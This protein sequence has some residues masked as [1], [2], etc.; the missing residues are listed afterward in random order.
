MASKKEAQA[1]KVIP[2]KEAV[3]GKAKQS[4]PEPPEP[5]GEYWSLGEVGRGESR[6]QVA[7]HV[8]PGQAP[9]VIELDPNARTWP[10]P[11]CLLD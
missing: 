4:K 8:K 1:E 7:V 5:S 3:K 11:S 6:R 2:K 9:R 10:I